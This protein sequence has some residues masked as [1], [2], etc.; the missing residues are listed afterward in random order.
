M[1]ITELIEIATRVNASLFVLRRYL[2]REAAGADPRVL[3]QIAMVVIAQCHELER[4]L[5]SE[6]KD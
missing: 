6:S 1:S 2:E 3:R 5:I 4:K